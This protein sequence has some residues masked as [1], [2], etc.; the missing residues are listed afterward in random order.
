[1]RIINRLIGF[2]V[3]WVAVL[4]V[5]WMDGCFC[6]A[7]VKIEHTK[8]LHSLPCWLLALYCFQSTTQPATLN[9]NGLIYYNNTY[10]SG[11]ESL[12]SSSSFSFTTMNVLSPAT[13]CDEEDHENNKEQTAA[14]V[15]RR[16]SLD[17]DCLL[18]IASL[19]SDDDD[20]DEEEAIILVPSSSCCG[21][22]GQKRT[23]L[24]EVVATSYRKRAK[25]AATLAPQ[26]QPK[27]HNNHND[28]QKQKR[29][30]KL[31]RFFVEP[32][33]LGSSAVVECP[34]NVWYSRHELAAIRNE[35]KLS[36]AGGSTGATP[37][38]GG[39]P[40]CHHKNAVAQE[41]MD[42]YHQT[43]AAAT[44]TT[45][46]TN[47]TVTQEPVSADFVQLRG[48]ER[49]TSQTQ[50]QM[51]QMASKTLRSELYIEQSSQRFLMM[52]ST[53]TGTTSNNNNNN[54]NNK[55]SLE[56][57]LA[58]ISRLHSQK[59]VAWAIRLAQVDIAASHQDRM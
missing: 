39:P 30:T 54:S 36:I 34:Q 35:C 12:S 53:S 4:V 22:G 26:S 56:E 6:C 10:Y 25:L 43:I 57:R 45:T 42:L 28:H 2:I 59:A 19:V 51:R 15:P 37:A 38:G 48:L 11:L 33:I 31:L 3:S 13:S 49:W 24:D 7:G 52:D 29:K 20:E 40:C 5:V 32:T 47:T 41:I 50:Y 18:D 14:A 16:I 1:M 44:T 46:T 23:R 21:V 8:F 9:M 58:E 17:E 55:Y 27:N